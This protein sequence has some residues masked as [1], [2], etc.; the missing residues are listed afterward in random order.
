MN[1]NQE[2]YIAIGAI[3]KELKTELTNDLS[4]YIGTNS[5]LNKDTS[6]NIGLLL[7]E[8]E[9]LNEKLGTTN[10]VIIDTNTESLKQI[11][12][13]SK[14]VST[15]E[16]IDIAE[17]AFVIDLLGNVSKSVTE[18]IADVK[19]STSADLDAQKHT[20]TNLYV[21]FE[22][23]ANDLSDTVAVV[24]ELQA[25]DS[26]SF[27][28]IDNANDAVM[29]FTIETL[30][31]LRNMANNTTEINKNLME[32][33]NVNNIEVNKNIKGLIS[34]IFKIN[35]HIQDLLVN[36]QKVELKF[37]AVSDYQNLNKNMV[38]NQLSVNDTFHE[39]IEKLFTLVSKKT[40]VS[41]LKVLID[42]FDNKLETL[43]NRSVV[44]SNKFN[45]FK[46]G[47]AIDDKIKTIQKQV[48]DK[49][50]I[51]EVRKNIGILNELIDDYELTNISRF[52]NLNNLMNGLDKTFVDHKS[53]SFDLLKAHTEEVQEYIDGKVSDL[54]ESLNS[55]KSTVKDLGFAM[56][57][58]EKDIDGFS[59]QLS[60]TMEDIE[61][62][63]QKYNLLKED[64]NTQQELLE[65]Y[66]VDSNDRK[67][68]MSVLF[69]DMN[70]Q[71]NTLV[72]LS[73]TVSVHKFSTEEKI[74]T[75]EHDLEDSLSDLNKG[76]I[77]SRITKDVIS[78]AK[79]F[80]DER[81]EIS[82][83]KI[84]GKANE[85]IVNLASSMKGEKGE[86]GNIHVCNEWE[87]GET[88]PCLN[89]VICHSG[90]W[91]ALSDTD[92]EPGFNSKDWNLIASGTK[93]VFTRLVGNDVKLELVTVDSAGEEKVH[94]LN[95]P[96]P[97]LLGTYDKDQDY[98][99]Y[100][101][102]IWKGDRW[103]SRSITPEG[104]PT[105]SKDWV[106]FSMHGP[107]GAKGL[108]GDI[109]DTPSVDS[110]I[111]ALNQ[112]ELDDSKPPI[113]KWAGLWKYNKKHQ[114]GDLVSFDGGIWLTVVNDE[115]T[116][117]PSDIN[118]KNFV[119]LLLSNAQ[120]GSLVHPFTAAGP[121]ADSIAG[122]AVDSTA[123]STATILAD[124][125]I[126]HNTLVIDH[127]ALLAV[128]NTLLIDHNNLLAELRISGILST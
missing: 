69:G 51:N 49:T 101:S 10:Q 46:P 47:K 14:S 63:N 120:G 33:V 100:D 2:L 83:A 24:K 58:T 35:D 74:G 88:T 59:D 60:D 20:N 106:L 128:H 1:K 111:K 38:K 40:D 19:N 127:N 32:D 90:L 54:S 61:T 27:E 7:D 3:L 6:D 56:K 70:T 117:P 55:T 16:N 80:V 75:I 44:L 45:N 8:V 98:G 12:A 29:K 37:D 122:P 18:L 94:E 110:V 124:L 123:T 48:N 107:R 89:L 15:L 113:R 31:K 72:D 9:S 21:S 79:D 77:E 93:D 116:I 114:M 78:K 121:V 17:E 125:V 41:L 97:N 108:K 39:N 85:F 11:E 118:N 103:I 71:A 13:L 53:K 102:V 65:T 23:I 99:F 73:E 34:S 4:N 104:E 66:K 84:I 96:L 64:Q 22:N 95:Y 112:A 26:P 52:E 87:E 115:G 86:E 62:V 43:A 109:G 50:D 68:E 82:D 36:K 67:E 25:E 119:L 30:N 92:S 91:Q 76:I 105:K 57:T 28:Y 42:E 5:V 81:G 126:D